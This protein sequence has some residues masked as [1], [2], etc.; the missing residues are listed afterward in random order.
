MIKIELLSSSF[1]CVN[2]LIFVS[3]IGGDFFQN[4]GKIYVVITVIA[5]IF[6]GITAFLFRLDQKI[7]KLEKR[8]KDGERTDLL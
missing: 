7:S 3:A 2:L 4:T 6:L 1:C 5:V 8:M